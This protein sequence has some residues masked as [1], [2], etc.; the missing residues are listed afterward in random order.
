MNFLAE[1]LWAL[2][3]KPAPIRQ[4]RQTPASHHRVNDSESRPASNNGVNRITNENVLISNSGA[5][6]DATNGLIQNVYT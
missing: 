5:N 6:L 3:Y 2:T 1:F 4:R